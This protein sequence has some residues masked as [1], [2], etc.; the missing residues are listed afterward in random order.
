MCVVAIIAAAAT[1][2]RNG[3]FHNGRGCTKRRYADRDRGAV[4]DACWPA[5][6][7]RG[8]ELRYQRLLLR[9]SQF[10]ITIT[11]SAM[12]TGE[13]AATAHDKLPAQLDSAAGA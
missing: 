11:N 3:V 8:L 2:S 7:P 6:T 4:F 9:P 13:P 12:V 5:H 10:D 1:A